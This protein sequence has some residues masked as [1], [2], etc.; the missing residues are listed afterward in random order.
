MHL[1]SLHHDVSIIHADDMV[2]TPELNEMILYTAQQR[3]KLQ[4]L[5]NIWKIM[6]N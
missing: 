2:E 4:S 6:C 1:S 3:Y 5:L